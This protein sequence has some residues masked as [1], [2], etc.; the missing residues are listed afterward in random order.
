MIGGPLQLLVRRRQ[1]LESRATAFRDMPQHAT[2]IREIQDTDTPRL[3]LRRASHTD[4]IFL[5][6]ADVLYV[7]PPRIRVLHVEAHH[8]IFCML[9]NITAGQDEAMA[10][11]FQLALVTTIPHLAESKVQIELL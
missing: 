4:I 3:E 2:R 1:H 10:F 9:R 6:Q 5:H 8:A 11:D 7:G